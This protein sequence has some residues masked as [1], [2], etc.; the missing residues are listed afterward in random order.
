MSPGPSAGSARA[1]WREFGRPL[2]APTGTGPLDGVSVAVKDLYDVAGHRVGAG[3]PAWLAESAPAARTAAAPAALLAAGARIAGIARTDEFAYSLTG[4][5]AHYGTPPNP[6]APD[7][8]PGGSSSGPA[9]AVALG[10]ATVGLGTDTAGSIRV[11]ASYQGLYGMR[12]THGVVSTDGVVPLAPSFD[13][14]GWIA[15]DAAT[16][17]AVGRVLLPGRA[18]RSFTRAIVADD[19]SSFVSAQVRDATTRAIEA[20]SGDSGLPPVEHRPLDA[21]RLAGAVRDFQ[22][23]Q[24]WEA[25]HAHGPWISRHWDSLNPD[26]RARFEAAARH[27][28]ADHERA[29]GGLRRFAAELDRFL[30]EHLL[31][32]PSASSV[33]PTRAESA[34]GGPV[35]ERARAATF[36]LTCVAG[37]TGRCAVSVPVPTVDGIPVGL[38]L[39][40]PRGRDLDVLELAARLGQVSGRGRT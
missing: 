8:I 30:G 17:T 6:A 19:L 28:A 39:V 23:V 40:G 32:L 25:W 18:R 21:G 3:N 12:P 13:T 33:A 35:V 29:V 37:A 16:L 27:T 38:S 11:P 1:V 34:L 5:N 15:R 31:L 4:T 36:A 2:I 26:V 14:V 24:G 7:R 22:T 9:S 10:E 20:W